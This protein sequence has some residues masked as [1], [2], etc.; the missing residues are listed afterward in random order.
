[1][2]VKQ[3]SVFL[4]NK[5]GT[6]VHV[7]EALYGSH[8]D[9]RALSLAETTDYGIVRLMVNDAYTAVTVLK[10][11]GFVATL[12]PVVAASIP[13]EPGGL[14]RILKV[15]CQASINVE[16]MYA[17]LGG[18]KKGDAYMIFRVSDEKN[19]EKVM[20]E[21]GIHVLSEEELR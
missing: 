2:S 12:T 21:N 4:E 8:V 19:T 3:V 1:M 5:G 17:S 6:L 14:N 11:A 20:L 15:L 9:I 10:D 13:D 7:T 16:Y 18:E